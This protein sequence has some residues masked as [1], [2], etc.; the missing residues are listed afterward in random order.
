[1][2]MD[3]GDAEQRPA[4]RRLLD[5]ARDLLIGHAGIVF[6]RQ[7][8]D[9]VR[10]RA[11]AADADEAHHGTD[12]GAALRQL[13]GLGGNVEV[14][15]LQADGDGDGHR[16]GIDQPPVIGGKNA[17]SRAPEIAVSGLTCLRSIA[18]RITF[19]FSKA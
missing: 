16:D 12:I 18:A 6:E 5:V 13:C 8:L 1:M 9:R 15:G 10:A 7:R 14:L 3:H 4:R 2:A 17:I 11:A 19:G